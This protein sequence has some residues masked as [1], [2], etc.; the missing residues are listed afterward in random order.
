MQNNSI[1]QVAFR[2]QMDRTNEV[3]N[4][5]ELG[6]TDPMKTK[7]SL[8]DAYSEVKTFDFF[9]EVYPASVMKSIMESIKHKEKVQPPRCIFMPNK[10]LLKQMIKGLLKYGAKDTE[11]IF[12][13][14]F[15]LFK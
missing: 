15:G 14:R 8:K 10:S 4:F 1:M 12:L 13:L 6:M 2:M 3:S 7:K 9:T 5:Y 11:D